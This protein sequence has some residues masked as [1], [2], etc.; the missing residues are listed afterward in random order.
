M[1]HPEHPGWPGKAATGSAR[2]AHCS[3]QAPLCLQRGSH[4]CTEQFHGKRGQE[5]ACTGVN[6]LWLCVSTSSILPSCLDE[7]WEGIR[8]L[9]SCPRGPSTPTSWL[10]GTTKKSACSRDAEGSQLGSTKG[11][12]LAWRPGVGI[13]CCSSHPSGC[14]IKR[15][16]GPHYSTLPGSS[17]GRS[18][19]VSGLGLIIGIFWVF[20]QV[21]ALRELKK[22]PKYK[23]KARGT[24]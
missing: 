14:S 8:E 2:E 11:S 24:R 12:E 13:T 6:H 4:S 15:T 7:S 21:Q 16:Q 19:S 1:L 5:G 17:G 10:G 3:C 9:L 20:F 22:N 23:I 18:H